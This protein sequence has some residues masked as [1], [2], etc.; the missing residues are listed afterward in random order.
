MKK[1]I[2][3]VCVHNSSRS[4]MAEG[5]LRHLY[6]ESYEVFSAGTVPT[7]LH[8]LADAAMREVGIDISGQK[9]K[10]LDAFAGTVFDLAVT[11]CGPM[12]ACP[13]VAGA[14]ET[15]HREFDDP[16]EAGDIETFRRVRD[17]IFG[18]IREAF[19]NPDELPKS[20]PIPLHLS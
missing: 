1:K 2:V 10:G 16:A 19:R 3:F 6:P 5:I 4:Q 8:P 9:S 14:K 11:V 17:E 20:P 15:V 7:K 13:Y 12:A 18:W